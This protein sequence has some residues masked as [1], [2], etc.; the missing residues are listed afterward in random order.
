MPSKGA[1]MRR[2]ETLD[3]LGDE[4]GA[5]DEVDALLADAE[6]RVDALEMAANFDREYDDHG[7]IVTI[8]AGAGGIDA[9]DWTQMLARMYLRWAESKGFGC[10][11]CRGIAR[12]RS[13]A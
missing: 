7:A 5:A 10:G 9:A 11:R 12:R 3:V 8:H 13:R 6:R 1:S 4:A 2:A